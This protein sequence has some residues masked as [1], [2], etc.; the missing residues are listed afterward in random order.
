MSHYDQRAE[1]STAF[2]AYMRVVYAF[3]RG[4]GWVDAGWGRLRRPRPVPV[5]PTYHAPGRG[6]PQGSP[7]SIHTTRVPTGSTFLR[8]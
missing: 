6:R 8:P 7:L 4:G 5:T 2:R 1:A 3:S